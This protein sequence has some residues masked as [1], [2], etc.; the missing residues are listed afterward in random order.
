[1]PPLTLALLGTFHVQHASHTLTEFHSNGVRA[2]L[3]YLVVEADRPHERTLIG[4][5]LWPDEPLAKRLLNLRQALYR[6]DQS[7]IP[8]AL[9]VP[10]TQTT[11]QT[12]QL[13]PALNPNLDV[14]QFIRFI[15][16]AQTH[17]HRRLTVCGP[18]LAALREA[19]ALY[20]GDFL[21]GFSASVPFDEWH[22]VWSARLRT[23][24]IWALDMLVLHHE[25]RGAWAAACARLRHWLEL[26]PWC[27]DAHRRLML[28]LASAGQ[29]SAALAQYEQCRRILARDLDATPETATNTL[30]A[31]LRVGNPV[32]WFA[33]PYE[34]PA[35]ETP[36]MGRTV[37]LA[38]VAA[39]LAAPVGRLLTLTGPGGCGKTRLALAAA[40][41]ERGAFADGVFFVSLVPVTDEGGLLAAIAE[42]LGIPLTGGQNVTVTSLVTFLKPRELLLVLDNFEPL[43]AHAHLLSTLRDAAPNLRLLVTSRVP[44]QLLDEIIL[45][46]G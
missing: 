44:L 7:L 15:T 10:F 20:R 40:T 46:V 17:R 38:A 36:L 14:R 4:E 37:A 13:N 16:T 42:R 24:T 35:V 18:C 8:A 43:L 27:E 11:R 19:V 33:P 45:R 34:V 12:V 30:V 2:L 31:R 39:Q 21:A 25:Q 6:L 29:R 22:T 26:E 9:P 1:M 23:Q 3:A 41:A 28:A 5:L 32:A